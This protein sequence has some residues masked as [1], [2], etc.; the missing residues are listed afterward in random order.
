[1][2]KIKSK[3][4]FDVGIKYNNYILP[5]DKISYNYDKEDFGDKLSE[6]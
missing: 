5:L 6:E 3:T 4:Y 1:M 2:G